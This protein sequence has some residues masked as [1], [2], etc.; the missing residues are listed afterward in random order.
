M[1]RHS[2][3][4]GKYLARELRRRYRRLAA[5]QS[6]SCMAISS[7]WARAVRG[8]SLSR[9]IALGLARGVSSRVVRGLLET[10]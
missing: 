5:L 7:L 2:S 6:P 10:L 3:L 9:G 4:D 1:S 8:A